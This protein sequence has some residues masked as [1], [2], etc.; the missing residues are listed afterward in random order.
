MYFKTNWEPSDPRENQEEREN[1]T[2]EEDDSTKQ[3]EWNMLTAIEI[4]E[5]SKADSSPERRII[6]PDKH[7]EIM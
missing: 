7:Y 1:T 3:I 4:E 5:A 2:L 6:K